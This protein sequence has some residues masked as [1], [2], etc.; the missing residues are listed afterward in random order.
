MDKLPALQIFKKKSLEVLML[1]DHLD[2]PC[3]QK[4][5]DYEGKKFVSI[6]KADALKNLTESEEE[7]N[8][9]KKLESYYK[10]LTEWWSKQLDKNVDKV[11]VS[12]R[13]VDS[14][15]AVVAPS[16]GFTPQ[17]EKMMKQQGGMQLQMLQMMGSKKVFEINGD[18]PVIHEMLKK[19]T[20]KSEEEELKHIVG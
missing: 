14:P 15:C 2:E 19:L 4:L 8:R 11:I 18:H 10:P 6:E 9:F 1:T 13:L 3:V 20:Q 5:A 12:K 16:H 7:Q 17:Q